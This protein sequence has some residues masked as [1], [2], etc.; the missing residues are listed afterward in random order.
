[1]MVTL[2]AGVRT[3]EADSAGNSEKDSPIPVPVSGGLK[4]ASISTGDG[5]A[6]GVTMNGKGY[7]W[8]N[9]RVMENSET[10]QTLRA[11]LLCLSQED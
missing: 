1:M 4:F 6:C 8:G 3:L 5:H 2:T 10:V 7:C 9:E 11:L